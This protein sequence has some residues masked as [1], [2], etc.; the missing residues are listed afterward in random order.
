MAYGHMSPAEFVQAFDD[1]GRPFIIPIHYRTFPLADTGYD[2]PLVELKA[3]IVGKQAA[4]ERCKILVIG[5][6]LMVPKN[7]KP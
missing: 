6:S 1:L 2:Q 4:A 7:L 5:E 3:A